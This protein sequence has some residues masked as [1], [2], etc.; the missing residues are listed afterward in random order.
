MDQTRVDQ[1]A[2]IR[3]DYHAGMSK[4]AI[5]RKHGVHRRTVNQALDS[6]WP[7]ERKTP[8][9]S[10]PKLD[11]FK[12]VIDQWLRAD[13]DAPPKQRHT[14]R[15]VFQRLCD[16]R[17]MVG[18]S[19]STVR[20]WVA[21]RKPQIWAERHQLPAEVFVPQAYEPGREAQVDFGQATVE[22]DGVE[23]VGHVF[24]M[25]LSYSGRSFHA[26]YPTEAQEAF[27]A[28]HIAAA[29]HFGGL[30]AR[31]R[32]DNLTPAVVRVLMGRDRVENQRWQLFTS[33]YGID[34]FYCRPGVDGAHEKGGVEGEVGRFRR[35]HLVPV[36]K[37]RSWAELNEMFAAF[38]VKDDA[39]HV[40]ERATTVAEDFE[41]E[42]PLLMP[43][44]AEPFDPAVVLN[45]KVDKSALISVRS[46]RYS[47]PASLVG[48]RVRVH[49]GAFDLQ[50]FSGATLVATHERVTARGATRVSLDHYLEV[51]YRKP[52][53][54]AGSVAL[55]QARKDGVFTTEHQAYWD[56]ARRQHGDR[57]AIQFLLA[58]LLLHR[59][60]PAD[61]VVAGIKAA[62]KAGSVNPQL[63]T[64]EARKWGALDR[65]TTPPP[66]DDDLPN[67]VP[68]RARQP[69]AAP[70][71][72]LAALPQDSRPLPDLSQWNEL[73]THTTPEQEERTAA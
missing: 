23:T 6:Q 64:I 58:V 37:A 30:P 67:V 47:V 60:L 11:A 55:A 15:R 38:D 24:N 65:A 5:A 9:R 46:V 50:V 1:F 17:G 8:V 4:R 27:I 22:I 53:A 36:P 33:W 31:I 41:A 42:R 69:L 68:I 48:Q 7:S 63:V 71:D 43:L 35:T 19:E 32:Y 26:V 2:V 3:F 72:V 21:K 73:L 25:R 34:A 44:P 62:L 59:H 56:A 54:M 51:L 16:E 52:G 18:V 28:G 10:A 61:H 40:G 57:E 70:G 12:P 13:L 39:R 14:A 66:P 45:V 29:A 20:A 49:L